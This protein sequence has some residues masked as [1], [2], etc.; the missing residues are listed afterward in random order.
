MRGGDSRGGARRGHGPAAAPGQPAVRRGR[1]RDDGL[2]PVRLPRRGAGI[3]AHPV[4]LGAARHQHAPLRVGRAV[5][6]LRA[7]RARR[8]VAGAA[9]QAALRRPGR[10]LRA[11]LLRLVPGRAAAGRRSGSSTRSTSAGGCPW[12]ACTRSPARP[13]CGSARC[14]GSCPPETVAGAHAAGGRD[15]RVPRPGPGAPIWTR[16]PPCATLC[17]PIS[18]ASCGAP[19]SPASSPTRRSSPSGGLRPPRATRDFRLLVGLLRER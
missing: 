19:S 17:A 14:C 11:R 7:V 16:R 12:W 15:G 9:A 10:P 18:R 8:A 4:A 13:G 3:P 1:L 6:V 5:G 2:Q